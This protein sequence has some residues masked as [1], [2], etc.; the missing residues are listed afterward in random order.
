MAQQPWL[1]EKWDKEA[2]VVVVGFGGAGGEFFKL[3]RAGPDRLVT[4]LVK[5]VNSNI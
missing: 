3:H 4:R 1:P 5:L 2:D